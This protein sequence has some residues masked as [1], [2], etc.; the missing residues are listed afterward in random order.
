[1]KAHLQ[2][3]PVKHD[4]GFNVSDMYHIPC[5]HAKIHIGETYWI[6]ETRFIST[7]ECRVSI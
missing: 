7:D 5:A 4:L 2:I 3:R 1:M 6:I